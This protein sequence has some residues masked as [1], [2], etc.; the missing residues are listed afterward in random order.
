MDVYRGDRLA[1]RAA[2]AWNLTGKGRSVLKFTYGK[3]VPEQG[4]A[5]AFDKNGSF[6][7]TYRWRDLNNNKK[8][9][10]GESNLS[11]SASNPD[12]ISTTSPA[13]N[14]LNPDLKLP[15]VFEVTSSLSSK[16]DEVSSGQMSVRRGR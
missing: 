13:N 8:Y 6:V 14:I 12:F 10:P 1:P 4:L 2:L 9:D 15:Y 7:T 11:T 16:K 3:F 5:G